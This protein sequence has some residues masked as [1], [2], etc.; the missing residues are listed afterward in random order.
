MRTTTSSSGPAAA[1]ERLDLVYVGSV[2]WQ[3]EYAAAIQGDLRRLGIRVDLSPHP[4]Y[5]AMV[6]AVKAHLKGP[7]A[8][9]QPI[10]ALNYRRLGQTDETFVA[11]DAKGERLEG[12][13]AGK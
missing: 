9:K 12:I 11:E 1:S 7:L 13:R 6:K 2:S 10:H 5:Q 8:D 4:N 3:S